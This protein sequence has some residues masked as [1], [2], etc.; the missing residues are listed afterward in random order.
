MEEKLNRKLKKYYGYNELKPLQMEAIKN[1]LDGKD[2]II[3]VQTGF[4]KSICYQLPY[5]YNKKS[6]VVISPLIS[7]MQ[8]QIKQLE[9][10]GIPAC[11][12]NSDNRNKIQELKE[13]YDGE[14]KIIYTTP[15]YLVIN[16]KMIKKLIENDDL[17]LIAIDE[18]HCV[19]TFGNDFR[20]DYKKLNFIKSISREI[21]ILALTATASKKILNNIIEILELEEPKI[22]KGEL[23]RENLKI[24][25][26]TL[27]SNG[28]ENKIK[29]LILDNKEKKILIYCK[30]RETTEKTSKNINE[31][32]IEC[33]PYHA[34]MEIEKRREIQNKYTNDEIRCI[35]ATTSFGMGVNITNIHMIIHMNCPGNMDQY[36]QEIGR[37]GRDGKDCECYLFHSTKDFIV[38][39]YFIS[40]IKDDEFREYQREELN[41]MKKYINS[42]KCRKYMIYRKFDEKYEKEKCGTCDICN[43]SKE[44]TI[45][46]T[47]NIKL[48][49]NMLINMTRQ[50][51]G[52]TYIKFL[53]GI[54][55]SKYTEY[56]ENYLEYY[57]K[58]KSD[59]EEYWKYIV[60]YLISN[61]YI[62]EMTIPGSMYGKTIKITQKG[63]NYVFS[64]TTIKINIK[65]NKKGEEKE[66]IKE[67]QEKMNDPK[68]DVMSTITKII[69]NKKITMEEKTEEKDE[70]VKLLSKETL[71]KTLK[72]INDGMTIEE[73]AEKK[74]IK[75]QTIETHIIQMYNKKMEIPLNKY[76]TKEK[77]EEIRGKINENYKKVPLRLCH[78]KKKLKDYSYFEI[79]LTLIINE[80]ND[81]AFTLWDK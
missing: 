71:Q 52:N 22:I 66:E 40:E 63:I 78:I 42:T 49:L 48:F 69:K 4:G 26:E 19:S 36:I 25:V 79:R 12:L 10:L 31:I 33:Y 21:P 15:E 81:Y 47:D 65:I 73:I 64:P 9:E 13:I 20:P 39:E 43:L 77:Y 32:G 17:G 45:D 2:T 23:D 3:I 54:K 60:N 80:K 34:G 1:I 5:L 68:Y 75:T 8:D 55:H 67:L 38:G 72:L 50:F 37:G 18:S 41:Y 59:D 44:E 57:G 51:G 74:K 53:L 58:G 16:Q 56:F 61:E 28:F 11:C 14:S 35:C 62:N 30:T 70:T 6:V 29:Q 24:Y 46:V 7:L 76:L 27:G